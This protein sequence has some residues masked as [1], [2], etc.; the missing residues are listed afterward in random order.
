MGLKETACSRPSDPRAKQRTAR[1]EG[2]PDVD[3]IH[4]RYVVSTNQQLP[5]SL[6]AATSSLVHSS[7]SAELFADFT[8]ERNANLL[9][10]KGFV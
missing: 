4:G 1:E 5:P 10:T 2:P 8:K 7:R 6:V 9:L 3:C